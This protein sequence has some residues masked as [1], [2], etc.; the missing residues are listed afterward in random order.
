MAGIIIMYAFISNPY[1]AVLL[2]VF[3]MIDN[4]DGDFSMLGE[5]LDLLL[6]ALSLNSSEIN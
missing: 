1:Q 3:S 2:V 5:N 6:D 4:L